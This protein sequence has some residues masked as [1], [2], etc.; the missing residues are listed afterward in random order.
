MLEHQGTRDVDFRA[1]K[2]QV[3]EAGRLPLIEEGNQPK[4]VK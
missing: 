2:K 3:E 1:I 4:L